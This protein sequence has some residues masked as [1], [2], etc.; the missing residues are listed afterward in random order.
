MALIV[1]PSLSGFVAVQ[2]WPRSLLSSKCTVHFV[3]SSGVSL[4][5]ALALAGASVLVAL[6]F[7]GA[8]DRALLLRD[9]SV[10]VSLFW[11]GLAFIALYHVLW[12]I[13]ILVLT[14]TWPL[15]VVVPK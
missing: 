1:R 15:R 10:F 2:V 7:H 11:V 12:V 9:A 3:F 5:V 4:L 14:A 13:F 8:A 6:A